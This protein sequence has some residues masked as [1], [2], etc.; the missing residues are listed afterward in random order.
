[1]AILPVKFIFL[2]KI[3]QKCIKNWQLKNVFE[4]LEYLS[5]SSE[6]SRLLWRHGLLHY[7][8]EHIQKELISGGNNV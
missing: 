3:Y 6:I 1:M 8:D 7:H 4:S 2:I 5:I